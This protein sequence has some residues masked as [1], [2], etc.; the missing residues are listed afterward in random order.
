MFKLRQSQVARAA[1]T[2]IELLVVIAIIAIL[3][4]LLLPAVQKVRDAANRT[5]ST[6]NLKQMGLAIHN[7]HDTN[8]SLPAFAGEGNNNTSEAPP[9]NT[10]FGG[11]FFHLLPFLEQGNLYDSSLH[12]IHW[13]GGGPQVWAVYD[14]SRVSGRLSFLID[15]GDPSVDAGAAAP[16]SYGVNLLP[17]PRWNEERKNILSVGDGTSN[18]IFVGSMYYNCSGLICGRSCVRHGT[19]PQTYTRVSSWN[20]EY[21][22]WLPLD[23]YTGSDR[24]IS[25]TFQ[26]RPSAATCNAY[27]A[28]SSYSGGILVALGD[29]S[30]KM[31]GA[32][33]SDA[34]WASA[35][36][37]SSG[38]L[39]GSDW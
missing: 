32:G 24:T 12:T 27:S 34:T 11:F 28:Q 31:V 7:Y 30:V 29:A 39:L 18:T 16:I 14:S 10:A 17:F 35:V 23:Q 4:G 38:D 20:D 1:F 26:V 6:N 25:P 19:P 15:P 5:Q 9:P 21:G 33:V 22:P 2:L 36:T 3:I 13:T 37:P 8:N